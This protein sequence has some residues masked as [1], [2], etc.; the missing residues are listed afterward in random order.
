MAEAYCSVLGSADDAGRDCDIPGKD[1]SKEH[2]HGL[3]AENRYL[4]GRRSPGFGKEDI[5]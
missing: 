1:H 2:V 4:Y 3:I 5:L